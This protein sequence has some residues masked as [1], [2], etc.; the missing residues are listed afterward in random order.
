MADY[1]QQLALQ[2][3]AL[4]Q[5]AVSVHHLRQ[6]DLERQVP[7]VALAEAALEAHLVRRPVSEPQVL[8]QHQQ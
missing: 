6:V 1:R 8:Q 5:Q 2:H 7:Q 3:L 4:R